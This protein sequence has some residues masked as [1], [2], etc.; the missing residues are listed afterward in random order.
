MPESPE[1]GL[2]NAASRTIFNEINHLLNCRKSHW[3]EVTG[4]IGDNTISRVF[5]GKVKNEKSHS[6][7]GIDPAGRF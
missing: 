4:S 5:D 6:H 2:K 3:I 1:I 7:R